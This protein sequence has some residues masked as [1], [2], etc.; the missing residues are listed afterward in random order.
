MHIHGHVG[1]SFPNSKFFLQLKVK[2]G[3]KYYCKDGTKN[4]KFLNSPCKTPCAMCVRTTYIYMY[5]HAMDAGFIHTVRRRGGG[6]NHFC[7]KDNKKNIGLR[8]IEHV[9]YLPKRGKRFTM[10]INHKIISFENKI[11]AKKKHHIYH[12]GHDLFA[13]LKNN[14]FW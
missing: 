14:T 3:W 8:W 9:L 13:S 5:V 10:T 1:I 6:G 4:S 11:V 7:Q 2:K 12:P